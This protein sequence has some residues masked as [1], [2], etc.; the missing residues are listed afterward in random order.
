[1]CRLT[2]RFVF[3]IFWG[4][5]IVV[6][7]DDWGWGWKSRGRGWRS[8]SRLQ[9]AILL[10]PAAIVNQLA[11]IVNKSPFYNSAVPF[12]TTFGRNLS[13]IFVRF[14][15]ISNPIRARVH[16]SNLQFEFVCPDINSTLKLF[17]FIRHSILFCF[18]QV[19]FYMAK[20]HLFW[21]KYSMRP[22]R[23]SLNLP[24]LVC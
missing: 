9:N 8:N 12:R 21:K 6:E 15:S 7:T 5:Y 13:S 2:Y 1:M 24:L 23:N 11:R 10:W 14:A 18:R 20:G 19:I 17:Q 16:H 22:L 3:M 4:L